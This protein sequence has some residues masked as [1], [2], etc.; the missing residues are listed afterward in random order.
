VVCQDMF[1]S[2][3][4]NT[5]AAQSMLG[6]SSPRP[7]LENAL[8]GTVSSEDRINA[9]GELINL[10]VDDPMQMDFSDQV[11]G[12][13]IYVSVLSFLGDCHVTWK[14]LVS[15]CQLGLLEFSDKI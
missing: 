2:R 1:L 9:I 6:V 11:S 5:A 4:R 10:K 15:R 3:S 8:T 12:K 7:A 14:E 13:K